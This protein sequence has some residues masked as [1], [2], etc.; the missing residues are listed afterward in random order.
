MLQKNIKILKK[1]M[2]PFTVQFESLRAD[3]L[4]VSFQLQENNSDAN[5]YLSKR[6]T[7]A[8]LGQMQTQC[9]HFF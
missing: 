9:L 8:D 2:K 4:H 3:N 5:D 1:S 7:F 6:K